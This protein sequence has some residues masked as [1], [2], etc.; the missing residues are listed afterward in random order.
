MKTIEAADALR[1]FNTTDPT[2]VLNIITC[3]S[4]DREAADVGAHYPQIP[5]VSSDSR[6]LIF[7]KCAMVFFGTSCKV[8]RLAR[9][10]LYTNDPQ[11]PTIDG[12]DCN[13]YLSELGVSITYLPF[14]IHKPPARVGH[15]FRNNFYKLDVV[16][17]AAR[18]H[19][20]SVLLA[21]SDVVWI[22]A[23]PNGLLGSGI[24]LYPVFQWRNRDG[25]EPNG[26]SLDDLDV[27]FQT[28][29]D[30]PPS[31]ET[32][33]IGGELIGGMASE[34]I[35][36]SAILRETFNRWCEIFD[37]STHVFPNG[38][39]VFDNDEFLLSYVASRYPGNFANG[40]QFIRRIWTEEAGGGG[41]ADFNLSAWHLPNEKL[42]GIPL[43]FDDIFVKRKTMYDLDI[44]AACGIPKR[45]RHYVPRSLLQRGKRAATNSIKAVLPRQYYNLI[46]KLF[47]REPI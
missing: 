3:I 25:R 8:N 27:I 32:E 40:G 43:L 16:Y 11:V 42:R 29:G 28:L 31:R 21:D 22:N 4:V 14:A 46:R 15:I 44:G 20:G 35:K 34:L 9:H 13:K 45:L 24:C 19:V 33:W 38:S 1:V 41:G 12:I 17:E 2:D 7:W 39:T 18:R 30:A 5:Y 37:D 23:L 36:F 47:G 6:R 26:V 10:Y